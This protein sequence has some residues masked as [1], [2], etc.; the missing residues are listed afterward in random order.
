[1]FAIR[2]IGWV[3]IAVNQGGMFAIRASALLRLRPGL[4]DV[5]ARNAWYLSAEAFWSAIVQA[6]AAFNAA[7]A[8]RLGAANADMGLLSSI[9]ALLAVI[10]P[11]PAGSFL[12]GRGRPKNWLGGS[13]A[14]HRLCYLLVAAIPWLLPRDA[15]RGLAAI[16]VLVAMSGLA[17]FYQVGFLAMLAE[18]LPSE[19]RATTLAARSII[20]S[21]TL[22]AC[23]FLFGRLLSAAEFP[24]N[25]QAMYAI[26]S[27]ASLLGVYFL[28]RILVSP[29]LPS[30]QSEPEDLPGHPGVNSARR[31][32][33]AARWQDLRRAVQAQPDFFR[34]ARNHILYGIGL[35]A[36]GPL[37]VLYFVRALSADDA[38]L[39]LQGA[40][41]NLAAVAGFAIW[42]WIMA[43][44]SESRTLKH[45]MITQGVYPLL[46]GLSTSLAPLLPV[47]GVYGFFSAGVTLSYTNTLLRVVPAA[48]RPGYL[49]LYT[50]I[51]SVFAFACP[52]FGVALADRIGLGPALV[53]CGLL[54]I[55]GSVSFWVWPVG[56]GRTGRRRAQEQHTS[57]HLS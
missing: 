5:N 43:R 16:L 24:S 19:R 2:A 49:G 14:I 52:W 54:S 18:V 50:T 3:R 27:L 40:V 8:V 46:T 20:S 23:V 51:T 36:A 17:Y 38:W 45:T 37:Y 15:P 7:Y 56:D 41:M 12:Q 44:W 48:R 11:V 31:L 53:V 28:S 10:V 35:W 34:L 39:G 33:W 9:P 26:G 29:A 55:L 1:M 57:D 32:P 13:L 47:V 4:A 22:S 42:R 21:V 25:Y 30:S 6:A